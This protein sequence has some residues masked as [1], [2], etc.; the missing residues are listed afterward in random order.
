M[1]FLKRLFCNHD[2]KLNR[3]HWCHGPAAME[4]LM[5]E[6]EYVCVKCGKKFYTH[7]ERGGAIEEIILERFKDKEWR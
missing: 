1:G 4:P 5:I 7:P 6:A 3:W 2:Y